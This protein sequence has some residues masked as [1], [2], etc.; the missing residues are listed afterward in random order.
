M[1]RSGGWRT[2]W[3]LLTDSSYGPHKSSGGAE[4]E[5]SALIW[6]NIGKK[7]LIAGVLVSRVTPK[8]VIAAAAKPLPTI[9]RMKDMTMFELFCG[10][11]LEPTGQERPKMENFKYLQQPPSCSNARS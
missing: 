4:S 1:G 9:E 3:Q 11:H 8:D 5:S 10:K 6:L 7:I 2:V